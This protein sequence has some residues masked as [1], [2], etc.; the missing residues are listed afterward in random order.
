MSIELFCEIAETAFWRGEFEKERRRTQ[1]KPGEFY[2]SLPEHIREK[3]SQ[4]KS[5]DF[6][7]IRWDSISFMCGK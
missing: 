2:F 3:L 6:K 4:L 5:D 7:N 1:G